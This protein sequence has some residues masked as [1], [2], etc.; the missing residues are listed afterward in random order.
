MLG[1]GDLEIDIEPNK[2]ATDDFNANLAEFMEENELQELAGD[3]CLT[4]RTIS[5]PAR[6]GCRRMSMA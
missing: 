3:C 6:I 1:L 5:T 2:E 4:L